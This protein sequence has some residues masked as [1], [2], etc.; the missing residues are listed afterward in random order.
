MFSSIP[1]DQDTPEPSLVQYRT[2]AVP[3]RAGIT[4]EGVFLGMMGLEG[5]LLCASVYLFNPPSHPHLTDEQKTV[6]G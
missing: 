5:N 4:V 6:S 3:H 2:W 1:A